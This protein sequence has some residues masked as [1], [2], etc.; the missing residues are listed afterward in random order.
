MI[1]RELALQY[2][3]K[4]NIELLF[5][6]QN[7]D[8]GYTNNAIEAAKSI[9]KDRYKEEVDLG[10]AW[11]QEIQILSDLAKRC[12]L[13]HG[14][15]VVYSKKILFYSDKDV[16]IDVKGLLIWGDFLSLA[17][18]SPHF[19]LTHKGY[20]YIPHEFKLCHACLSKQTMKK[21]RPDIKL[22]DYYKHP[23]FPYYK[24]LGY[25]EI[26]TNGKEGIFFD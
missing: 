10:D 19:K 16:R 5:I 23:L 15:N 4:H 22:E 11:K 21:G 3:N 24:L 17:S 18:L 8:G 9:L 25:N 1:D 6:A 2:Q 12:S 13:C 20:E 26:I 7:Y 14:E